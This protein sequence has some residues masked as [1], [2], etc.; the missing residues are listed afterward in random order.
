MCQ[1]HYFPSHEPNLQHRSPTFSCLVKYVKGRPGFS[2]SFIFCDIYLCLF[3]SQKKKMTEKLYLF[4][5]QIV[6]SSKTTLADQ[7]HGILCEEI[8]RER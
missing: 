7:V 3:L 1:Y 8:H 5:H 4:G 2:A 6:D